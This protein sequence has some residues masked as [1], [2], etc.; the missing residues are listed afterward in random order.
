MFGCLYLLF[1][2]YPAVFAEGH[3]M[4]EGSVGLMMLPVFLGSWAGV[5]AY[6]IFFNPRYERLIEQHKPNMVPP[7]ERLD[8]AIIGAP[9][10][11]ISFFWFG[12]TSYPSISYWAPMLSGL[13]MG[14]GITFI[15]VSLTVCL[16]SSTSDSLASWRSSTT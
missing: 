13:P 14:F 10:F 15:N 9:V 1:E 8:I 7:E 12:W 5:L 11:A 16:I 2:A 4:S 6:L 3:H